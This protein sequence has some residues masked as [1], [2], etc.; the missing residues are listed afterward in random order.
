MKKRYNGTGCIRKLSG[1]R[2]KPYQVILTTAYDRTTKI[3]TTKTI[4]TFETYLDAELYLCNYLTNATA[5]K[6]I[7]LD[8]L[9]NEFMQIKCNKLTD[10]T[11]SNY[12]VAFKKLS[13]ISNKDI[14]TITLKQLQSIVN[15][16]SDAYQQ[17]IKTLLV[18]LYDFAIKNDYIEKNIAKYIETSKYITKDKCVFTINEIDKISISSKSIDVIL[19]VLLYTGMRI[20]ELIDLEIKD[21]DLAN[22]MIQVNQSKTKAGIRRIPIHENIYNILT[23]SYNNNTRYIFEK[24]GKKLIYKNIY[25]QFKNRYPEHTIHETRHTFITNCKR[26]GM[27]AYITKLIAGHSVKDITLDVYT[28]IS[29]NEITKEFTKFKY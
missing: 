2:R 7:N 5:A 12:N 18:S 14:N 21:I 23:Y 25:K 8:V 3:Q 13:S 29:A 6:C 26:C 10:Y 22:H 28:H 16:L 17:R 20:G 9:F 19:L 24:N 15:E 27:D 11:V 1:N 4:G